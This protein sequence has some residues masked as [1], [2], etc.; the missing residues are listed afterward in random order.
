MI[1]PIFTYGHKILR[2]KCS[3]IEPNYRDL[4]VL[5]SDMW[6]TMENAHGCGLAASQIGLPLNL[7]IVD[8]ESTFDALDSN[9]RSRFFSA[10]DKGI[11]E[12]FINASIVWKSGETWEDDEGC[13][14]IPTLSGRVPRNWSIEIVYYDERFQLHQR[15]FHGVTARMIQH[16]YDHTRGILYLD[17]LNPLSRRLM[18]S[19]LRRIEKGIIRAPYPTR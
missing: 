15:R 5:I 12:T 7:F 2:E 4:Q 18:R 3:N 13:L 14:S 17:H 9:D 11:Q 8:S 1:L 10:D 19:S 16:E 6:A